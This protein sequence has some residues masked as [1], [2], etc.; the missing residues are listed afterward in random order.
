MDIK[1]QVRTNTLK[2]FLPAIRHYKTKAALELVRREDIIVKRVTNLLS[3]PLVS[4][5]ESFHVQPTNPISP[6]PQI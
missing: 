3:A 6:Y 2:E 5:A 4:S 1:G